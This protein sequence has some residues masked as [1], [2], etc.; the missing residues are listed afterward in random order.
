MFVPRGS[1]KRRRS[2]RAL[3]PKLD[4]LEDRQLMAS[5]TVTSPNTRVVWDPGS[6]YNQSVDI[7]WKSSGVQGD[8]QIDLS[9]D[10]GSTWT[11]LISK[12]A[13]DGKEAWTWT[14]DIPATPNAFVRITSIKDTK[15]SD[16]SDKAFAVFGRY[17]KGFYGGY[18]TEYAAREFDRV[19]PSPGV[20]WS[21]NAGTWYGNASGTYKTTTDAKQA[22]NGSIAVWTGG[23][24]GH[25]AVVRGFK[26]DPKDS[27]KITHLIVEEQNFGATMLDS[28]N[29][30]TNE[31]GG[32]AERRE[33]PI[34]SL[35]R[36]ST[37]TFKGII[38]PQKK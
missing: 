33:L 9:T 8:V 20:N 7:T 15:V 18:C 35:N 28:T 22:V 10:N 2:S 5:I 21:G 19:A 3:V 29:A 11:S 31:F 17:Y 23:G 26:Y 34:G 1:T 38:L 14:K 37:F 16:T 24:F 32:A 25:V 30:I 4:A 13:N 36:G 27:K 6:K 12:T